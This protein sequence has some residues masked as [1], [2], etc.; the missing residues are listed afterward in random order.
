MKKKNLAIKY[1]H[2][3]TKKL[4]MFYSFLVFGVVLFLYLTLST[5]IDT[6]DGVKSLFWLIFMRAGRGL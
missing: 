5:Q 1:I 4:I 2:I 6:T 3:T